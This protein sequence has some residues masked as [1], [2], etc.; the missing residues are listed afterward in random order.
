MASF[1][2]TVPDDIQELIDLVADHT[3]SS[4]SNL[5]TDWVK[6]GLYKE[7]ESLKS[8]EGFKVLLQKKK[9]DNS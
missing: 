8:I 9:S 7:I 5:C 4:R 6:D 1:T 3:G 2:I